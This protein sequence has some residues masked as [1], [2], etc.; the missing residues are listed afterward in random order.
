MMIDM[1]PIFIFIKIILLLELLFM[2]WR[3]RRLSKLKFTFKMQDYIFL[4][5]MKWQ[6]GPILYA[7]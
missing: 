7:I 3:F 6:L 2:R 1:F 4:K 5:K